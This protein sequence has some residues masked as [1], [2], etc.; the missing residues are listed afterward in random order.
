M[1]S[2]AA[3][4]GGRARHPVLFGMWV[5]LVV[6]VALG[7]ILFLVLPTRTWLGQRAVVAE[8]NRR[9]EV[10]SRENDALAARV[11]SLQDPS[12]VERLA[13]Q[14]YGMIRPGERAY[15]VLPPTPPATL[16]G[17]W[18]YSVLQGILVARG[19]PATPAAAPGSA[20]VSPTG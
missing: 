17:G 15:S 19:L 14:Q 12:Q 4:P 5:T 1:A 3:P 16:P 6:I 11:T 2:V 10:L 18:P 9:L 8:T 13:R 20:G 7:L